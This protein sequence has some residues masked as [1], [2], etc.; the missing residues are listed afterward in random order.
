MCTS[1]GDCFSFTVSQV[2]LAAWYGCILD[3]EP[4]AILDVFEEIV[5]EP[6]LAPAVVHGV[7]VD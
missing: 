5:H 1:T 6:T 4:A 2:P 3:G 7:A